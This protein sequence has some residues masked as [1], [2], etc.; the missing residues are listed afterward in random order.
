MT[1]RYRAAIIGLGRIADTIDDEQIGS[2]WLYPFSHMGAYAEVPDVELVGASDV[3]AEQ[4]AT[5]GARWGITDGHLYERY[6]DL[7]V[8][9]RPDILSICTSAAPRAR[10]L[11]DVVR[12]VKEHNLPLRAIWAEKP[13]AISLAEADSMVEACREARIVLVTNAMRASDVYYR[14][15]R[16][17]IDAGELGKMLQITGYGAGNLSHMGVHLIGAMCVLAGGPAP[18]GQRVSW[19]V[20]ECVSGEKASGDDDLPGNA[21]LA[22]ENGAR[23]FM[24]MLPSGAATWTLDAIGETGLIRIHNVNAGYEFELWRLAQAV[25]GA[26]PT[27]ARHIFPRPQ[28]LWSA[29]VG[30]LKDIVACLDTGKEPNCSGDMGRHLLE[31]AIA[32]RESHRRG[33]ARVDLPLA[34]RTLKIRSSETLSGDT[35]QALRPGRTPRQRGGLL[36]E[37]A[38]AEGIG[39][40]RHAST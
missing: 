9:R 4:R 38:Q 19:V 20:G 27:P 17:L 37:I 18:G 23:G 2:G 5:F 29:A 40:R 30:Q 35:P 14:R 25:G 21:Y 22:F 11:L 32:I 8:H 28:K 3:Y 6:Q 1:A 13:L 24:R 12:L 39:V 16:A 26:P 31:I 15:A 36:R 7:L 33:N 10:I 34:D